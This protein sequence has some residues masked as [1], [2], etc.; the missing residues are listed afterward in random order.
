MARAAPPGAM[1]SSRLGP[2][3]GAPSRSTFGRAKCW[4]WWKLLRVAGR[5]RPRREARR[6]PGSSFKP[7]LYS[8]A[9]HSRRFTPASVLELPEKQA[10]KKPGRA[11]ESR[12]ATRKIAL[13]L[14]V[15]Q[16]DNDAAAKVLE[17][18]GAPNVVSW[19]RAV[20]I[21]SALE[22]TPSRARCLR[23]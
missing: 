22:P 20:G 3:S 14:A 9:L 1:P 8:Y 21:E 15:A 5:A 4:R 18:V 16:S 17:E 11:C 19:A 23:G 7:M 13:R 10:G 2:E 6:Q 12:R